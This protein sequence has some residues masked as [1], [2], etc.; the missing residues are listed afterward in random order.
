MRWILHPQ[1]QMYTKMCM[2]G[3]EWMSKSTILPYSLI[4]L[5]IF[6]FVRCKNLN[7][8]SWHISISI[9]QQ[10]QQRH[11]H[12]HQCSVHFMLPIHLRLLFFPLLLLLSSLP[13]FGLLFMNDP[14]SFHQHS[15]IFL[16][17]V[18][19]WDADFLFFPF[20]ACCFSFSGPKWINVCPTSQIFSTC[21]I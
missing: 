21:F 13:S 6:F 14:I 3:I 18:F 19:A 15:F 4:Y 12:H 17:F 1:K 20:S 16:T 2:Y 8:F 11:H 5:Y 7:I 9:E 10:Q